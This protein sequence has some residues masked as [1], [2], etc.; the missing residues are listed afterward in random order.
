MRLR[1]KQSAAS[2]A[3]K[4]RRSSRKAPQ[5]KPQSAA[6]QAAKRRKSSRKAPQVKPQSAASQAAKRR[7]SSRVERAAAAV[8]ETHRAM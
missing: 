6:S 8:T 4:C 7:K 5:V 3:A 2:Q 1:P